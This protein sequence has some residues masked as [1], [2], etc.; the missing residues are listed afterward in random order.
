[1]TPRE[2]LAKWIDAFNEANVDAIS[3]LYAN[4]A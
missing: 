4:N 2:V 1:M 3:N